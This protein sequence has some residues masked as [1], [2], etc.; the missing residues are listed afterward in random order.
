MAGITKDQV[1]A[2]LRTVQDP[3]LHKDLVTLNMIKNV[4]VRDGHVKIGVELTTPACPLKDQIRQDVERAVKAVG[5][6][7][8]VELDFTA[9]VRANP[10][11]QSGLPGVVH[12]VAVICTCVD[13]V[14][15]IKSCEYP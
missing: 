6:V 14:T 9:R 12:L 13:V 8:Q 3:E 15:S 10:T 7:T 4:A 2:A 1:M 5:E 11:A